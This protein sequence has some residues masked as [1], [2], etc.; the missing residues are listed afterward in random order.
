MSEPTLRDKIDLLILEQE[1]NIEK[2]KKELKNENLTEGQ[3]RAV[4]VEIAEREFCLKTLTFLKY[5]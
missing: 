2:A 3:H 1:R 4:H 5:D